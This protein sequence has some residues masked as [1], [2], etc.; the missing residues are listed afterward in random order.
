MKEFA[1]HIFIS[2]SHVDNKPL[3]PDQQGWITRFHQ[4]FQ[5]FLDT[6][7][8]RD[9]AIWRDDKLSGND[10]FEDEIVN[11][12]KDVAL[13]IS[14]LSPRY[15]YSEWCTREA[16]EFCQQAE[17]SGGLVVQ[18]KS[19]VL[20]VVKTP[21]PQIES[22]CLPDVFNTVLGYDF[23]TLEDG[24][25]LELDPEYGDRF[26][27]DYNRKIALLAFDA[28][29]LIGMLESQSG[30]LDQNP[31]TPDSPKATIYV[32]E[33][34]GDRREARDKLIADLKLNGYAVVPSHPLP[35]DD[36]ITYRST[37]S[38]LL[39][40][41]CLSIHLVGATPG[42]TPD[43]RSQISIGP[44]Q[45]DL[46]VQASR[47]TPL[48]RIVWLPSGTT[49]ANQQQQAFIEALHQDA[50]VQAGAALSTGGLEELK[51]TVYRALK[52]FQSDIGPKDIP[53]LSSEDNVQKKIYFVCDQQDRKPSV[54]VRRW[55]KEQ[56]VEILLPMFAG[57]AASVRETN[58]AHL[59][60]CDL[61]LVHYGAGDEAW[62]AAIDSDHRK[63]RAYRGSKPLPPRFTYLAEPYTA[64]KQDMLDMDEPYLI[65]CM[66]GFQG[67][68]MAEF[69]LTIA[70]A[71]ESS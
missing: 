44:L 21:F 65:D 57:D 17:Q 18:N 1:K 36:E 39:S 40:S 2:Y 48:K 22:D 67:G 71:G 12:F 13:L 54:Q 37:A 45:N 16:R 10:V 46:A 56:G 35:L 29:A 26:K 42:A 68:S 50:K 61:V 43:G 15:I 55:L 31:A 60:A 34:S 32:A 66:A 11:Q 63:I 41:A 14:I 25:P 24:K 52:T 23:Y 47:A 30:N 69:L 49:S 59:A 58:E 4:T 8:G 62:K 70:N 51:S 64:H 7:L 38:S 9:A 20:K 19:R 3:S 5:T 53:T 6:R 33:C 28:A 27:Q